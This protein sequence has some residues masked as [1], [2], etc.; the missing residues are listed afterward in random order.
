MR[1]VS[2]LSYEM[3]MVAPWGVY[4]RAYAG[5]CPALKTDDSPSRYQDLYIGGGS[6]F[7][8]CHPKFTTTWELPRLTGE[9]LRSDF[10]AEDL[11]TS[12]VDVGYGSADGF[13][14][15][16]R[17]ARKVDSSHCLRRANRAIIA[18]GFEQGIALFFRHVW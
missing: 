18:A 13:F 11:Q 10:S 2:V 12:C 16:W 8:R 9:T 7:G 15:T 4:L 5:F 14:Q 17:F 1:A 6:V 3:D